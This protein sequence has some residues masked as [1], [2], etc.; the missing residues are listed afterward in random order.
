[1][2]AMVPGCF[3]QYRGIQSGRHRTWELLAHE[4]VSAIAPDLASEDALSALRTIYPPETASSGVLAF[5]IK[6]GGVSTGS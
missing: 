5:A 2:L 6:P 1:M 4:D 3:C